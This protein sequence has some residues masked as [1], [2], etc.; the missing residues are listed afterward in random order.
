VGLGA[1]G[2]CLL[3]MPVWDPFNLIATI[4]Q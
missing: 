1:W 4:S 2:N 3:H